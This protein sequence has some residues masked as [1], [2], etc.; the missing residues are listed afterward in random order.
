MK[1][2]PTRIVLAFSSGESRALADRDRQISILRGRDAAAFEPLR[3][4][5]ESLMVARVAA[6]DVQGV[7]QRLQLTGSAVFVLRDGAPAQTTAIAKEYRRA[8]DR[9]L[10]RL[11]EVEDQFTNAVY[12]LEESARLD[13]S[14]TASAEWLL[15]NSYL[16]RTQVSEMRR[17]F[18]RQDWSE[19]AALDRDLSGL[20]ASLVAANDGLITDTAIEESLRE[21]Q[22]LR[23]L[24][25][26][27]LWMFPLLLRLALVE[28][29][30]R[31]ATRIDASQQLREAADLWA[32][33]LVVSARAG[34]VEF[35]TMLAQLETQ[36]FASQPYFATSL[37]EQL[38]DEEI[39]LA[40]VQG[41]FE[42]RLKA[43]L[44]G[45]V[46]QEH[47]REAAERISTANAFGSLRVLARLQFARIFESVSVVDAELR[48]DP[49]GIYPSS[50]FETRDACRH[51][52]EQ[53]A[54]HSGATEVEVARCAI[55][56][57]SE[58]TAGVSYYLLA[59]GVESVERELRTRI[60]LHTRT[61]RALRRAATPMYLSAIVLLTAGFTGLAILLARDFGAHY[62]MLF[63]L[64]LLA[65][66][67]LSELTIQ[68]LNALVTSL[69]PP[70]KLPKMKFGDAIPPEHA[71]LAVVPMMLIDVECVRREIDKLEVRFLA[72]R[73]ANLFYGLLSDF[74]DAAEPVTE[75]DAAV[76]N[77][78]REGIESLNQ[79]YAGDRFVLLHRPRTWSVSE[80]RWIGRER[81]R[82]KLEDLNAYL[83][84]E[85]DS[86]LLHAG[87]LPVPIRYVIT[88]DAD[89]QL[90]PGTARR[91][92][93]T[94]A[95]PLNRADLDPDTRV[96]RS[97]YS[98]IQPRVSVAL[99]E[100]TATR[101]TRVFANA[102][103]TDP[104]CKTVSD[105]HQD[106]F[107]EGIFHGK[108]IYDV[109][110]FR[111]S[112]SE[113]FPAETLL[114]H[115]LIEGVHVGVGLASDIELFENLPLDYGAYSQREHRWIRGDWQIAPWIRARVPSGA[116]SRVRNPLTVLNRWRIF[117]N[118][119]RSLV[120]VASLLLLLFGWLI[121]ATP[122]VWS[123]VLGLAVAIP[124]IAPLLDRWARRMQGLVHGWH[125][126]ADELARA[127]VM[128]AFLP[129][130]AWLSVDA[131]A[132][133]LYRCRVSRRNLLQW[134]TADRAG[135]NAHHHMNSTLRQMLCISGGSML[136]MIALAV[137]G[138]FLPTFAFVLLWAFSPVLM[139]WLNRPLTTIPQLDS[140]ERLYIRRRARRTWRYFDDLVG[141]ENNWLPPDNSQLALRIEVARRTS[142]TN[143]GMWLCS[144]LAA[145]DL[146]YLSA[147]DLLSRCSQTMST[148]DRLERYEGHFLN[149]YGTADLAPLTP[150]YVSTADSGNLVVSLWTLVQGCREIVRSPVI[151][152]GCVRGLADTLG[153][154][155]EVC[156]K[157][158]PLVSPLAELQRLLHDEVD[159][160]ELITQLR[161][162]K[163][164]AAQLLERA[165]PDDEHRYWIGK[166]MRELDSAIETVDRY[167]RWME[168]LAMVP[169][170]QLRAA[171][172]D[173]AKLR[174]RALHSAP[175]LWALSSRT[176]G[177]VDSIL[178]YRGALKLNPETERWLD[179]VAVEYEAARANAA[180]SVQ[181]FIK[182]D[183]CS[184]RFAQAIN[185]R[186]LY[187]SKRRL[188]GVGYAIGDPVEF[189]SHYDLL[190]SECRLAS[191]VAIA[192]G[193]V[194][195][196]HWSALGRPRGLA[197]RGPVLMSWSGT[198]FEYLMPL[199]FM[200]DFAGSLIDS[201][202][203]Q[204]VARQIEYGETEGLP[205]GISESAYS[206]LDANQIYQYRAFGVPSLALRRGVEDARVVSPYSTMLALLVDPAAA[207]ANLKR[208][209]AA[210]LAGPM[211]FYE[212]VDYSRE[213][214]R[215]GERG[216]VINA[217]MAHHQGMSLIALND[218]LHP[219]VMQ[220]RFH[221]DLRIRA[222]E[223]LLFERVPVTRA[224]WEE[225]EPRHS[226]ARR[227]TDTELSERTWY[228]TTAF[229]RV[230]LNGNGHYSIMLTNSCGGYS[231]W[232]EFDV[233]RWRSDPTLDPWGATVIVS[234]R[235]P[236]MPAVQKTAV[237]SADR[238]EFKR[239]FGSVETV[240]YVTVSPEDDVELRRLV[241]TNHSARARPLRITSYVEL[242]LAPHRAD[243]AHPAF[244]KMFVETEMV[245]DGVLIAHRRPRSPEDPQVWAAHFLIGATEPVQFETDRAK[246]L[247]EG[248]TGA[249]GAVLDPIF[250]LRSEPTLQPRERMELTFFI[251]AAASRDA[252]LAIVAKYARPES[253]SRA[254]EMAWTR[255]QLH[256]RYLGIRSAAAHRFHDLA[257]QLLYPQQGFRAPASRLL[258]NRLGQS[259]LWAYGISGD[260]PMLTV[261]VADERG[262]GLVREL[263]LAHSYWRMLGFRADLILLEQETTDYDRP[264][265]Q[266]LIRQIEAHASR[267]TIDRPGGVF[268][269][270]WTGIPE[271]H[272]NLIL[273]ASS[274]V[275]SGGRGGLQQQLNPG[276]EPAS[277][278]TFVPRGGVGE[279]PSQPLPFLELPYFNGLGGFTKDGREYAIYLANETRP[280]VPWMNVM[281]NATFG[282]MVSE[283]GLGCTWSGNSQSN[284]LTPWHNDPV[285]DPQSEAIYLRD[286]ESGR[287]WTPTAL[288][289]R[290][291]DAY[292]ARHGSGYTV[293]EHNSHAIGQELTVFVP[294]DEPVKVYRLRLR[295]DSSRTRQLTVTYFAEWVLGSVREDQQLH[296]Q[297]AMDAE[298]GAVTATQTWG[299]S[300]A[301][302]VAF[303]ASNPRPAS[304]TGDRTF[305]LGRDGSMAKP[306]ALG[307]S[308]LGNR[309][310][311]GLDPAVAL[312]V[313]VAVAPGETAEVTFVLGQTETLEA[314]RIAIAH[315][316]SADVEATRERWDGI[317]GTLQV[318]TPVLSIDLLLNRW[319][320]YQ[321]LSCRFWG[322]SALYQSSGAFGFR[323]QLQ[324]SL[325][326]LYSAP[327][328]TRDH[329]LQCAAR[330]FVE[331]DV[332]HWWH[333]D[334]GMGVRTR[335]SDDLVWLPY[336]VAQYIEIT[337][338]AAI[339]DEPVPFLQAAPLVDGEQEHLSTPSISAETQPLWEH[340]R[341]VLDHAWRI[342]AHGL[343]LMGNGDWND[344]LNRVGIDGRGESVWL[345]WFLCSVLTSFARLMERRN[346]EVAATWVSR[347]ADLAAAAERSA[348]DGEWY[349]RGFFDDGSPLGARANA[350]A[351]IDS[352]PQSW[353]AIAGVA[354]P[355]R[356]RRAIESAE[357][358]LVKDRDGLVL[359]FAPPF[360]HSTPHPGYIM[361]YPLGVREN[362]GQYTHGSLWLAMG[363]ARLGDAERAVRLLQMMNPIEHSRDPESCARYAAEPYVVAADVSSSAGRVGRAGWTWYTGSAAWMYR[364]WVEEVLG[365]RLRGDAMDI[366]PVIPKGWPGF[367][368]LYKYK[369]ASYQIVVQRAS[370]QKVTIDGREGSLPIRLID[371]GQTHQVTVDS[372]SDDTG[373]AVEST[374]KVA[375]AVLSA[376]G[377]LAVT[378]SMVDPLPD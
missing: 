60:P 90:P 281:A 40:P 41:W 351:R 140:S 246:Y 96:R 299:G 73:E 194:P 48:M 197:E 111:T 125:G 182:L 315:A 163:V 291:R 279:E 31:L 340:C 241:V 188:F 130:Q 336:A 33:R 181:E 243:T 250:S 177:E 113:R 272:R 212:S 320:L 257:G 35:S 159:G 123:L 334:S 238:A 124:A 56:L 32:N 207:I 313:T 171:G 63:V 239:S 233:T 76:L 68:V 93:E 43:P 28:M 4:P 152:P 278:R 105:A 184:S 203:R 47:T 245:A 312:Q 251:C 341:R 12:D 354:D 304:W 3:L 118:L 134:E 337:G 7:V 370:R 78:A 222:F 331:G 363:F 289:I 333:P 170:S 193:D 21:Y 369:T 225:V 330:Q 227:L 55:R 264:L 230:H 9:L 54:R 220:R 45:L 94:I 87:R 372:S 57:S 208:L 321:A 319:L 332:Q 265:H 249:T 157:D 151:G 339:L 91:L 366:K 16:V 376:N 258:R 52:V 242:S 214:D 160:H 53:I 108:A 59:P 296:V 206:M 120:P 234:D 277:P 350:E 211:G 143:I 128:I 359:L 147:N 86:S 235:E 167:L 129:H 20:A 200:R 260:L 219:E 169:D 355:S 70:R 187:D 2:A 79:R 285:L 365:F 164:A 26:G 180:Q 345:A 244:A 14:L 216:V 17:N 142:P 209:E 274:V 288:P 133:A 302:H 343:P 231:R 327:H 166:L 92:V 176:R 30:A 84:G 162:A 131:I 145:H 116:G 174:R 218:V 364:L 75:N 172:K 287:V 77:A 223:S 306:A 263:L 348:W 106:L 267:D 298:S 36:S 158:L 13:H 273:A 185:M 186:F 23:P 310:G 83:C 284:R 122:G 117:D 248:M 205:W 44:A 98:V 18:S 202:C 127:T 11:R 71:T 64:G 286:D 347:A 149:W 344:G 307:R 95:H 349:L 137:K 371:D 217:Y 318:R 324:D 240:L 297:T 292:R 72:N 161:L 204:A 236:A 148:L 275:F 61:I 195:V 352:L 34:P 293:Y 191:L 226:P 335:C 232:N 229:P 282:T 368:I 301:G 377:R 165:T 280:P 112:L 25:M 201:A 259:A 110:A 173:L 255:S 196:E 156:W 114:S 325:A 109:K 198:M 15:D 290:E 215:E 270:Y 269:R 136:L 39:A 97:G 199:L 329:I 153:I 271:E 100:A 353:A 295:N 247:R 154:V 37:T 221:S 89:T 102:L 104:Y 268:L 179:Q 178:S 256:M 81:K 378:Q 314:A 357:R 317:C 361:G 326:F 346:P 67:P 309:C 132:R 342:G 300:G 103:G 50:D 362:G 62:S 24:K 82:G 192:K 146:G 283:S 328:L 374:R 213:K 74:V 190:A 254:F 189:S 375:D 262:L 121:S 323:D 358:F 88:L 29:L 183:Q 224:R 6:D 126:A 85:G 139:I 356:V 266:Q 135:A 66:F 115:D 141:P 360:E 51:V 138:A 308:G 168:T 27:G 276:P 316:F 311:V 175:S 261:L 150:R 8:K 38:H 46:Q 119:R 237:F 322:R 252:L 19:L 65:L 305:F 42:D 338:D 58:S 294:P 107:E 101:F 5:G 10:A 303:A 1:S 253:V 210:G 367:E 22:E 80:Q 144:A 373:K 155:Q 49:A 99:P 69:L 228:P